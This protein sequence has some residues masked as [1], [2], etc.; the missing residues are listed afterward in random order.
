MLRLPIIEDNASAWVRSGYIKSHTERSRGIAD[1]LFS[2]VKNFVVYILI[3]T[4]RIILRMV[5]LRQI[6]IK[7]ITECAFD[8]LL[9][10]V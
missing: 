9:V 5:P 2:A 3:D 1:Y 8:R 4:D 7:T 6:H 10:Q